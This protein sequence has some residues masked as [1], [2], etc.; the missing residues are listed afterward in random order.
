M[1]ISTQS[2]SILQAVLLIMEVREEK[3]SNTLDTNIKEAN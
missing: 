1:C 3:R 2:E